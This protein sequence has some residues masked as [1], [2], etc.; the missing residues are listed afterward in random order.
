MEG[1]KTQKEKDMPHVGKRGPLMPLQSSI[2]PALQRKIA[3]N[4]L[5][6]KS[7]SLVMAEHRS[8][9]SFL[10]C[11]LLDLSDTLCN[12]DFYISLGSTPST[13]RHER[14]YTYSLPTDGNSS[15]SR[16]TDGIKLI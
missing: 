1:E 4:E 8:H 16:K 14:K 15:L 10:T 9:T 3:A 7:K 2:G 13:Q 11:I 5:E 6:V 12:G